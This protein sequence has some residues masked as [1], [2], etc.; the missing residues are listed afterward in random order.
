MRENPH[1]LRVSI[2]CSGGPSRPLPL[3]PSAAYFLNC[4]RRFAPPIIKI[5]P[6]PPPP[7]AFRSLQLQDVLRAGV[8]RAA[9]LSL[10]ARAP[11]LYKFQSITT[12]PRKGRFRFLRAALIQ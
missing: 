1:K 9:C 10:G 11:W 3:P 2:A 5:P 4:T 7:P 6:P 8:A 12:D